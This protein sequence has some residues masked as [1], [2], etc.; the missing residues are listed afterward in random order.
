MRKIIA[1]TVLTVLTLTAFPVKANGNLVVNGGF[2]EPVVTDSAQWDIFP[3][4]TTGLGWTVE[5]RGDIPTSWGGYPRPDPSLQELHAGVNGWLP[6]ERDQ[7]AELDTDW[8][9][10]GHPQN[11]EPASVKIY[12]NLSTGCGCQYELTFWFS[13]RPGTPESDNVLEVQWGGTVLGTI[14]RAGNSQTDWS[15]HTYTVTATG[16]TTRLQFTDLG[17][18]NSL[19]TFLDDVSVTEISCPEEPCCGGKQINV[20]NH[21]F[22][23]ND[24]TVVSK[25]GG[26]RI[27]NIA[28]KGGSNGG[29][30]TIRT[31]DAQSVAVTDTVVNSNL[32]EGCCEGKQ[33]NVGNHAFVMNDVTAVSKTG[34]N[35]IIDVATKGG[36]SYGNNSITTGWVYSGASAMT[37]VNSNIIRSW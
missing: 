33:I 10:P 2:E 8:Y 34:G 6:Y 32:R 29:N 11:N 30:N 14:S 25:T 15:E 13:P 5:W 17:T 36:T 18:A 23:I 21:A 22:V 28:S 31:G 24:V 4:G 19:G 1:I 26:N 3:D 7:Y 37:V 27:I 35:R 16:S 9:G 20:G 12:Q